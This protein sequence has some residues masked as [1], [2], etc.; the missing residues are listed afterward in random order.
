MD[1]LTRQLTNYA[2]SLR[3][4][5]IPAEVLHQAKVR[6]IDTLGCAIGGFSSEPARIARKMA[7]AAESGTSATVLGTSQRAT[8]DL[9]AFANG[10][11]IRYLDFN[12]T[13]TSKELGHPSD[14]LASVLAAAEAGGGGK[15]VLLGTVLSYELFCRLADAVTVR[16]GGFDYVTLT[17][18]SSALTAARLLGLPEEQM[19]EALCLAMA[20]NVAL[21][22]TRV[23]NVSMWK[24][25][26]AANACRNA[27]FAAQMA[28]LGMTGP[29]P[30]FEGRAGF[31]TAVSGGP[32]SVKGFGGRGEPFK[33]LE[34]SIKRYPVG[35]LAQT[36]VDAAV[37]IHQA[38]GSPQNIQSVDIQLFKP[39]VDIMAGD[40]EKWRPANRETAD[41]SIPYAVT[42]ALLQGALERRHFSEETLRD[43]AAQALIQ[44]VRVTTSDECNARWPEEMLC[45]LQ[46]TTKDGQRHTA[47]VP[48]HRG[49]WKDPLDD[50]EVEAK[51]RSMTEEALTPARASELLDRLWHMESVAEVVEV[52]RLL[53]VNP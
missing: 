42:V 9:A 12:D 19:T 28:A 23:G 15:A 44:K 49:H 8:P 27:L 39:A 45:I 22:Q 29:S 2:A 10:V 36:V 38:L 32:F 26:A 30:A 4:D 6:I 52:M 47:R 11:A 35:F 34:T 18:I 3:L 1:S 17:A 53:E 24:A 41:H 5:E 13:Y 48:Y 21:F 46:V 33:L 31:F 7:G 40:E 16:A 50:S 43:P 14:A 20:P 37:Q 51:F 25:C